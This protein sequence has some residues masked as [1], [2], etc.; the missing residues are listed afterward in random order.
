VAQALLQR[1][2]VNMI[3]KSEAR[4]MKSPDPVAVLTILNAL[5][6]NVTTSLP[7]IREATRGLL[8]EDSTTA[9]APG[10]NGL[11]KTNA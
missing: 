7:Q 8:Q 4:L 3:K 10:A 2:I 6:R 9:A 1:L 11:A 5:L